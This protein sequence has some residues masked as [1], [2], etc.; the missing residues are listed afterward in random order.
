MGGHIKLNIK[1]ARKILFV[2]KTQKG[3]LI[4]NKSMNALLDLHAS[5]SEKLKGIN[6]AVRTTFEA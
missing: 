5:N 3:K 1:H 4:I 2:L 6:P